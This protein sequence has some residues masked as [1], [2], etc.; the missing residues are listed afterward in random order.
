MTLQVLNIPH[1]ETTFLRQNHT[2][3]EAVCN[4]G[5][6]GWCLHTVVNRRR[7]RAGSQQHG[8]GVF[9]ST[10]RGQMQRRIAT[11][12]LRLKEVGTRI[13]NGLHQFSQGLNIFRFCLSASQEVQHSVAITVLVVHGDVLLL[14]ESAHH[15]TTLV[16]GGVEKCTHLIGILFVHV[17]TFLGQLHTQEILITVLAC[18]EKWTQ[19][20]GHIQKAQHFLLSC[21]HSKIHRCLELCVHQKTICFSLQEMLSDFN[22]AGH[23]TVVKRSLPTK[24]LHIHQQT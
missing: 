10:E 2:S 5:I 12:V 11:V 23:Y 3:L 9:L 20:L 21:A 13:R 19:T 15:A 4:H 22:L 1:C 24:G 7:L 6:M 14:E 18:L 8:H 17:R 16:A